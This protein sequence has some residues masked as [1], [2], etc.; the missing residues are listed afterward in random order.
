MTTPN[1]GPTSMAAAVELGVQAADADAGIA[2]ST[3]EDSND[4]QGNTATETDAGA[5]DGDDGAADGGDTDG[6]A[7]GTDLQDG[8]PAADGDGAADGEGTDV[9]ADGDEGKDADGA[10]KKVGAKEG[11]AKPDPLNDPLPEGVKE[12]TTKRI[13]DLIE[14]GKT[15][16]AR[17]ERLES[18]FTTIVTRVRETG[19]TPEQYG[20]ALEYLTLVNSGR[21]EDIVKALE[22]IDGERVALARMAGVPL[23][24][25]SM[26]GDYPDIAAELKAGKITAERAEELAAQRAA[27]EFN[28]NRARHA[29]Q[30]NAQ[31]TAHQRAVQSAQAELNAEEARLMKADPSYKAKRPAVLK[32]VLPLIRSGKL[33]PTEWLPEFQRIYK[34]IAAPG[35]STPSEAARTL[36]AQRKTTPPARQPLRA[37][38]PAGGQTAAPKTMA[39]AVQMGIDMARR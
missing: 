27:Q 9:P 36:A 37:T 35:Q 24:G 15:Q 7:S 34:E 1:E 5:P 11:A 30:Q 39:D 12:A 19:S 2:P 38:Q 28:D 13:K 16:T 26:I 18:Q 23:P 32:I 3:Q 21:R 29:D 14:I 4:G 20:Q 6:A 31:R 8:Q 25:V 22:F 10:A 33:K 17:A